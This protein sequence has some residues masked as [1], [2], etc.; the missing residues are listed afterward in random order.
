MIN[1][2]IKTNQVNFPAS[3]A[4]MPNELE[5]IN[6]AKRGDA[7]AFQEI[8]QKY[9]SKVY[10][11]AYRILCNKECAEDCTQDVFLKV[12]KKLPE[13]RIASSF[14][15]WLYSVTANTAI[16]LQRRAAK[17]PPGNSEASELLAAEKSINPENQLWQKQMGQLSAKALQQLPTEV[18]VAFVLRHYQGCSIEEI[19]QIQNQNPNTV[20]HRIFRGVKRLRDILDSKVNI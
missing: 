1:D 19:S 7:L 18:R 20:K 15:T 5:Q 14:S 16:D 6:R 11:L 13:Y 10:A 9:S 8:V 4:T 2:S 12:Y 17:H 3:K